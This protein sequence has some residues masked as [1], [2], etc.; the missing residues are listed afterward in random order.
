MF[1][2]ITLDSL[3]IKRCQSRKSLYKGLYKI[4]LSEK[5]SLKAVTLLSMEFLTTEISL[6][7]ASFSVC[8][9]IKDAS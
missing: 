1:R 8:P 5:W 6:P 9:G 7:R 4:I 3:K 2:C